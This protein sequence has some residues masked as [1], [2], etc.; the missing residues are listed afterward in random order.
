[1]EISQAFRGQGGLFRP[2]G[3]KR[4]RN[5]GRRLGGPRRDVR[6]GSRA[7]R[8]VPV[9]DR[10][11]KRLGPRNSRAR[12]GGPRRSPVTNLGALRPS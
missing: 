11:R 4:A 10:P 9:P 7:D 12:F 1:M 5:P 8:T 3:R 2:V 6:A